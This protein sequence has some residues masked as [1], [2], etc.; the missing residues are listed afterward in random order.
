MRTLEEAFDRSSLSAVSV[1]DP[2]PHG[3]ASFW[4]AGPVSEFG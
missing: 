2:D 3:S 4:E 1:V